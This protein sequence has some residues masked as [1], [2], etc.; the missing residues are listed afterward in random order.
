[1]RARSTYVPNDNGSRPPPHASLDVLRQGDMVEK[2]LQKE[3][4]FLLLVANNVAGD[5][6]KSGKKNL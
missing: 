6:Q 4:G 1:M 5:C 2:E 3:V